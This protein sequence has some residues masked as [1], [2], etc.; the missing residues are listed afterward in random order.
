MK[1]P[2]RLSVFLILLLPPVVFLPFHAL[3]QTTT[4][5]MSINPSVVNA[6]AINEQVELQITVSNV[7]NLWQWATEV[8]WDPTVLSLVGS[9]EEG[10]FLK[11]VGAT[12]FI[13]APATSGQIPEISCTLMSNVSA[14]GSGVLAT[15]VFAVLKQ[16]VESP[17]YLVNTRLLGP[18]TGTV[19]VPINA[20]I[21]HETPNPAVLVTFVSGSSVVA[22][23][24]LPQIVNEDEQVILNGSQSLPQTDDLN[25]TWTFFDNGQKLLSG[26]I[27][28]YTFD[29]PGIY[30]VTL[31]VSDSQGTI[32]NDTTEITVLD[33]TPPVVKIAV[34]STAQ[35]QS[36]TT[37]KRILFD[38][39]A[40]YDPENGTLDPNGFL[41]DFGDGSAR[42]NLPETEHVYSK[43]GIFDVTL[44]IRDT[45]GN[46]TSKNTVRLA[47]AENYSSDVPTTGTPERSQQPLPL[48]V[49]GLIV[50]ITAITIG[51]SALWLIGS[52]RSKSQSEPV[53][54]KK[55]TLFLTIITVGIVFIVAGIF[56]IFLAA[57]VAPRAG[58]VEWLQHISVSVLG[59]IPGFPIAMD[60]LHNTSLTV[61]GTVSWIVGLDI[62]VVGIGLWGNKKLA[63]WMAIIIFALSAYFNFA[64]FLLL[65][66][67]GAPMTT[68]GLFANTLIL[69]LLWRTD[70][71][72]A[73]HAD[74]G[75]KREVELD[76][77]GC[78]TSE[79]HT[80]GLGSKL[81]KET[82]PNPTRA[83]VYRSMKENVTTSISDNVSTAIF[84]G[85]GLLC[86]STI[87][88]EITPTPISIDHL[89]L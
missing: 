79:Y 50:A 67:L 87:K 51:G 64:Q 85:S 4:V 17:V 45:R 12:L 19:D 63:K 27:A 7:Q 74:E 8:T 62:F 18:N 3:G 47:I 69:Y 20:P 10:S 60:D 57:I 83:I 65:G 13:C 24:G 44:A 1:N 52:N 5:Y 53:Q 84:H 28:N 22:D 46:L 77:P 78:R 23:A 41:W 71:D 49:I 61:A 21:T 76:Q 2:S 48:F 25:Y 72:R 29:L 68:A 33:V 6:H 40:S 88:S 35:S 11:Q 81:F 16:T 9:P 54:G 66:L 36:L 38:G 31:S 32:P 73:T 59:Q 80:I 30:D 39:R 14:S 34:G 70:F 42:D 86:F 89:W 58:D 43:S 55:R 26:K 15:L 75:T 56:I 37:G 82:L